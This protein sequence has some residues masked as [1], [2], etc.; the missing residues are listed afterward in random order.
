M[1]LTDLIVNKIGIDKLLHALVAWVGVS[2]GAP[3]GGWGLGIMFVVMF[4]LAIIKEEFLDTSFDFHDLWWST[5]GVLSSF[6]YFYLTH[7]Y[8]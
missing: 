5:F 2:L 1:K 7:I 4:V 6:M 3:F 8:L